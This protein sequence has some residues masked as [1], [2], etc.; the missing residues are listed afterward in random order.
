MWDVRSCSLI[1]QNHQNS[2]RQFKKTGERFSTVANLKDIKIEVL[3]KRVVIENTQYRYYIPLEDIKVIGNPKRLI[4]G[5]LVQIR[6]QKEYGMA[7]GTEEYR[8]SM[9]NVK[10]ILI[11]KLK[12]LP[13]N[14]KEADQLDGLLIKINSLLK[15][16]EQKSFC[17]SLIDN[18]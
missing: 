1:P 17:D 7:L 9:W 5:S 12:S 18:F 2:L 11:Q 10:A 15:F 16:A 6:N 3:E 14:S 8:K 4:A 13:P